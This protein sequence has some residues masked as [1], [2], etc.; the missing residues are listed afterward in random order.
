[1]RRKWKY[2]I[3]GDECVSA[4]DESQTGW[5]S[6]TSAAKE[7]QSHCEYDQI[8][9]DTTSQKRKL[10]TNAQLLVRRMHVGC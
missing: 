9:I 8:Y 7:A 3:V 6:Q 1:M 10:V 4:V 5:V 2:G